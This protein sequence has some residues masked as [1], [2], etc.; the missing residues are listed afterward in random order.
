MVMHIYTNKVIV[1]FVVEV[2]LDVRLVKI[3]VWA[4]SLEEITVYTLKMT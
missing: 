1:L 4:T 3:F 2:L